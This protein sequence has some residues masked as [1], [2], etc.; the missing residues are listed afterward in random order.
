M[1]LVH[2]NGSVLMMSKILRLHEVSEQT[3]IPEATLR[4]WRHSGYGP[5]SAKLGRRVVY[6][7][8]DI[9]AWIDAQF[10]ADREVV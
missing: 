2:Y 10:D 7:E 3:G 9:T 8:A 4:F 6:R 5:P 1:V